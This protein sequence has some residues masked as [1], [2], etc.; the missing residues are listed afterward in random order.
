[1][2][3]LFKDRFNTLYEES[4]L[5]QEEFGNLFK[6]SKSQVFHWRNGS[7]EPDTEQIKFIANACNVSTGWLV[8]E[9]DIKNPY[10]IIA[11]HRTDD[12]KSPLPEEALKSIEDFKK[13]IYQKHGIK[14]D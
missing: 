13:F 6:A 8:G 4:G 11:A 12:P 14:Y 9:T 2:T 7:G 3:A 1:M 10:Q 5:T